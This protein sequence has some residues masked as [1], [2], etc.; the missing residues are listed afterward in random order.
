MQI[1]TYMRRL[2]IGLLFATGLLGQDV[3]IDWAARALVTS[4]PEL[5]R[6]IAA[7]VRVRN[8]NRVL[9]TYEVVVTGT[10]RQTTDT[11]PTKPI[12]VELP[13]RGAAERG[14]PAK[15]EALNKQIK[16]VRDMVVTNPSLNPRI[17]TDQKPVERPRSISVKDMVQAWSGVKDELIETD[18]QYSAALNMHC[19]NIPERE[20]RNLKELVA[21]FDENIKP[22][23]TY[24]VFADTILRPDYDYRVTI[25]EY[26]EGV[27]TDAQP[28][29][30]TF[31]PASYT[32]II[33]GGPIFT[34]I[35]ARTYERRNIPGQEDSVLAVSGGTGFRPAITALLNY[36]L[37]WKYLNNETWGLT[38]TFG[39]V[40]LSGGE[41]V[42]TFG[43]FTG[44]SAHLFHRVFI[45]P[46]LHVGEFAD[47]P[48]GVEPGKTIPASFTS[49]LTPVKR[50]TTRFAISITVRTNNVTPRKEGK[51]AGQ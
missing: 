20:Y 9:Y 34:K 46:G 32:L 43:F 33:S 42:S 7:K 31:S 15:I 22:G 21:R 23:A 8:V 36:Q 3:I 39:P 4:P 29:E 45:T 6:N 25:T 48:L 11:L 37:P 14:C 50:W 10:P 16:K 44:I 1:L 41:D 2:S 19:E 18:E 27:Q 40:F 51:P 49:E 5:H 13:E 17:G 38:Y 47:F 28:L 12:Q 24:D 26:Y 30:L 35:P